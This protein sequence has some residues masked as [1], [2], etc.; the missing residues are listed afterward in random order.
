MC[1][2]HNQLVGMGQGRVLEGSTGYC[3]TGLHSRDGIVVAL[4]D[5]TSWGSAEQSLVGTMKLGLIKNY[6]GARTCKGP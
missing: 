1:M 6:Y 3:R 4:W 5:S 2:L